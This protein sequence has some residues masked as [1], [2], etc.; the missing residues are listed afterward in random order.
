[1]SRHLA[2]FAVLL[3]L[4]AAIVALTPY[5]RALERVDS[6]G[7]TVTTSVSCD[8]PLNQVFGVGQDATEIDCSGL[9]SRRIIAAGA[10]LATSMALGVAAY[11]RQGPLSDLVAA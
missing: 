2:T 7:R 5:H 6:S 4:L 10:L 11:R 3:G 1:M 9:A 8:P